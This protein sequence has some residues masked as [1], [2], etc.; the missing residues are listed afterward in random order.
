MC[1]WKTRQFD[2]ILLLWPYITRTQQTDG[3][4]S[5]S[6]LSRRKVTI[7]IAKNYRNITLTS[8]VVKIYNALLLNQM[9]PASEKVLRRNQNGFWKYRSTTSQIPITRRILEVRVKKLKAA[10]LFVDFSKA[11]DSI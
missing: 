6:F 8:K 5:V 3:R 10:L 7:G 4:K 1:V 9:E 2:D 11:I